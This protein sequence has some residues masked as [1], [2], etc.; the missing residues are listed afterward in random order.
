M[1]LTRLA[2]TPELNN[3][4]LVGATVLVLLLSVWTLLVTSSFL[5]NQGIRASGIQSLVSF[6]DG[7]S[8]RARLTA[9]ILSFLVVI[10]GTGLLGHT[11]WR[12]ADLQPSFSS[13]L[14]EVTPESLK[15]LGWSLG[16][17]LL[18]LVG[19]AVLQRSGKRLMAR[20]ERAL[21]ER[22]IPETQRVHVEK[23]LAYLPSVINLA[24]ANAVANLAVAALGVPAP[25]R[26]FI[27]T[28]LYIL[29]LVTG[30]RAL[31]FFLYF[32]SQRLVESWSDKSQGTVLEDYYAALRRL[33]PV[34]Q[35]SIE[36]IMYISVAT[37]VVHK[38]QSLEPFAPYGPVL[39]RVVSMFFA[40]SVVVE[41][42]RV[43]GRAAA[44]AGLLPSG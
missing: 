15:G 29:L 2:D 19:F 40:A 10:A 25:V 1:Q 18:L 9:V 20:V 42:S 11:L 38:F 5:V 13:L 43:T 31:V 23:F 6:G 16:L 12:G 27:T 33:L 35:K 34:G 14:G 24:L 8:K 41:F 36:A 17:L 26:W 4:L 39:I 37:L 30:G 7:L 21:Q 32:L 22:Q 3:A 28:S 44:H